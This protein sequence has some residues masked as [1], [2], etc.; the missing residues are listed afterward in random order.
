MATIKEVIN[1]LSELEEKYGDV[2][3]GIYKSFDNKTTRIDESQ[4]FY[5]DELK[6]AYI[7]IYD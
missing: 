7:G 4:I 1:K 5:D 6:N 3:L 2:E